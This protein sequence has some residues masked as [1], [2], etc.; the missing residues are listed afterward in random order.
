MLRFFRQQE[1]LVAAR[2]RIEHR[3]N[4]RIFS[5]KHKVDC[6]VMNAQH[7]LRIANVLMVVGVAPL[8]ASIYCLFAAGSSVE[9]QKQ[10]EVGDLLLVVGKMGLA[11]LFALIV[12]GTSAVWSSRVEKRNTGPGVRTSK[13]IRMLV[14]TVLILPFMLRA[15]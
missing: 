15:F 5:S 7:K 4:V 11:Y 2:N 13:A 3:D 10:S 14:A 6:R 1:R 8:L 12:S 9:H